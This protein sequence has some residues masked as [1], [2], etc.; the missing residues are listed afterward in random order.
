[1]RS[2]AA[3]N[4]PDNT[5]RLLQETYTNAGLLGIPLD[6]TYSTELAI[7]VHGGYE[8]DIACTEASAPD[9]SPS[10]SRGNS[11]TGMDLGAESGRKFLSEEK[12]AMDIVEYNSATVTLSHGK[13]GSKTDMTDPDAPAGRWLRV[14]RVELASLDVIGWKTVGMAPRTE[15]LALC[16]IGLLGIAP[17]VL[18]RK[19]QMG[20]KPI[21]RQ[22]RARMGRYRIN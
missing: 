2:R 13:K 4:M 14:E 11:S 17:S 9:L 5:Y 3:D 1:M 10:Y 16:F 21:G 7:D 12:H 6:A 22:R 15:Q 19:G 8:W 20:G 18:R